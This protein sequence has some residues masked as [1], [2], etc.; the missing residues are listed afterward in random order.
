MAKKTTPSTPREK[1]AK[2]TTT[3]RKKATNRPRIAAKTLLSDEQRYQMV[4]EAAYYNAE[5]RGFMA[6]SDIQD[7]LD[8][9]KKVNASLP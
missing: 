4:A 9:E 2:K 5:K 7:W 8:A 6:G 3:V 1:T